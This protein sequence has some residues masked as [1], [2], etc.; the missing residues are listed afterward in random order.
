MSIPYQYMAISP[1]KNDVWWC[2]HGRKALL[3]GYIPNKHC[4]RE[5]HLI[6]SISVQVPDRNSPWYKE[7]IAS[8]WI[9][10]VQ[11]EMVQFIWSS[12]MMLLFQWITNLLLIYKL[13]LVDE[14]SSRIHN[15]KRRRTSI[16]LTKIKLFEI[17][18]AEIY[19][20]LVRSTNVYML[21][22]W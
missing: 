6:I 14:Q 16:F 8:F 2:N 5:L 9:R 3:H 19:R 12:N 7:E 1:A 22:L 4:L 21:P 13:Q 18:L 17:K 20:K 11:K 15:Y 10:V